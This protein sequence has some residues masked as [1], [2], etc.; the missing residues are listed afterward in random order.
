MKLADHLSALRGLALTEA[1]TRL[2]FDSGF[3]SRSS[4]RS[5][6]TLV[7]LNHAVCIKTPAALS[8]IP[9]P[10]D[11]ADLAFLSKL[12]GLPFGDVDP[13]RKEEAFRAWLSGESELEAFYPSI[14][15]LEADSLEDAWIQPPNQALARVTLRT[16]TKADQLSLF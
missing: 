16:Y 10:A 14:V 15:E 13:L 8:Q 3:T 9:P 6:A 4:M 7:R 12:S 11:D 5:P 2:Y 1:V